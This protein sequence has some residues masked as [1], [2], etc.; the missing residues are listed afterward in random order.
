MSR[1]R[2]A[3]SGLLPRFLAGAAGSVNGTASTGTGQPGGGAGGGEGERCVQVG[4]VP[5]AQLSEWICTWV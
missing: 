1:C 3:E 2:G 4:N 5:V